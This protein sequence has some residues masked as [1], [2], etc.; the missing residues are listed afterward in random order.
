MMYPVRLPMHLQ[1]PGELAS[2]SARR[3]VALVLPQIEAAGGKYLARGG[4]H[5]VYEGDWPPYR[6]ALVQFPSRE[7]FGS[8][9]H[10]PA[11]QDLHALRDEVSYARLV[12]VGGLPRLALPQPLPARAPPA[13]ADLWVLPV[14]PVQLRRRTWLNCDGMTCGNA[15]ACERCTSLSALTCRFRS[16]PVQVPL[17]G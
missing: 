6:L 10:S 12:G 2:R 7:A 11:Y 5:T 14:L 9:Y 4:P 13:T 17:Q 16:R 8:C 15:P 3:E 1:D